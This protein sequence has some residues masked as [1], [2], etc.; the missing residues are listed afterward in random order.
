MCFSDP[1]A[2]MLTM[3]RNANMRGYHNVSFPHSSFKLKICEKIK[4]NGFF[5]H[6]WFDEKKKIIKVFIKH[7]N[8]R[9]KINELK[10]IS[11]PSKHIHLK[12]KEINKFCKRNGFFIISTSQGLFTNK[13]AIKK[14]IGGKVIFFIR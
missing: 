1:V 6:Y 12:K 9:S 7:Q 10:K 8:K 2:N 13:E 3:I 14:N 11:T 5:S 4:E